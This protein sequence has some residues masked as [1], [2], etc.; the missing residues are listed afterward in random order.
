MSLALGTVQLGLAY[1]HANETGLPSDAAAQAILEAAAN[2]FGIGMFDTAPTYGASEARIG[3]ADFRADAAAGAAPPHLCTKVEPPRPGQVPAD[4]PAAVRAHVEAS[5][6][7][8]LHRLR[9]RRLPTVLLHCAATHGTAV[10]DA[11]VSLRDEGLVGRLGGSVYTPEEAI[12][13]LRDPDIAALQIPFSLLDARWA[14]EGEQAAAFAA[15]VAARPDVDIFVRSAL[16]QGLL[17]S[18]RPYPAVSGLAPEAEA[19]LRAA[20]AAAAAAAG[21]E[22]VADLAY[23]YVR[24]F[25]WVKSVVVGMESLEQLRQNTALF[26]RAPLSAEERAEVQRAVAAACSAMPPPTVAALCDPRQWPKAIN[27]GAQPSEWEKKKKEE[28]EEEEE[29]EEAGGGAGGA[30]GTILTAPAREEGAPAA[31]FSLAGRTA[32]ITGGTGYLGSPMARCLAAA[33]A[34]VVVGSSQ[35][36]E[37]AEAIAA[38]LPVPLG[39]CQCHRGVLLN[40][41]DEASLRAGF[42]AAVAASASGRVDVLVNNGLCQ[43][44]GDLTSVT[45]DDFAELQRNNAGYFFLAKL[46]RDLAV[47]NARPASIISIGSMYGMVGSYPDAYD[48]GKASAVPYHALKGGTLQMTRH[49]SA[50]YAADDV[51]VNTLSPGPFPNPSAAPAELCARLCTKLPA[52]RMGLPHELNGALLLLASDAGSF[53]TGQNIIVDG[54]WTAW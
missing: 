48:P 54:G 50:Y 53:I 31:L 25:P 11:L 3:A 40:Q 1:G 36:A 6:Y 45:F 43:V 13:L 19:G 41:V 15:A 32:L 33:G 22:N 35:S 17:V 37:A 5:V 46:T 20:L 16:L 30:N 51:R 44:P 12:A 49:L 34:T 2:D 4:C 14:G 39:S 10:W 8:S 38:A 18:D 21:R 23:A 9:V 29:E 7:R 27:Q 28:E 52:K 26:A 47:A 24:S 42:D